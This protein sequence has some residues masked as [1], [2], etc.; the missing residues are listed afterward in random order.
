MAGI[1]L[2]TTSDG[3]LLPPQLSSKVWAKAQEASAVMQLG[4]KI[5]V[6]G[7]GSVIDIIT[8]DPV[9]EWV[10]QETDE[11]PVSRPAVGNKKMMPYEMAVIVPFSNKF[12]RDKAALYRELERRLPGTLAT[13]FDKTVFGPVNGAPGEHFDTLGNATAISI[14]GDAWTGLVSAKSAV[15]ANDGILNGWALSPQAESILLLSKDGNGRPLF[16]NDT[17]REGDVPRLL[18]QP[19]HI[20]KAVFAGGNPPQIGFA[21]D[22]EDAYWGTVEGIKIA[23]SDQATLTDSDGGTINL[24]Q[25]NMF[26]IRVEAEFG[27]R[28]RDKGEFVKLTGATA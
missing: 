20:K 1:D 22:W 14:A 13:L 2:N 4:Q 26:A 25:R 17:Q 16:I 23:F 28:V 12:K 19:A 5:E 3:V 21:G 18:A 9:A 11:K 6:P 7:S 15:G 24:W 10:T 27:F 8:G